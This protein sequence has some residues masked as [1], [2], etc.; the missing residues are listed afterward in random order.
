M[1]LSII[2]PTYN[3]ANTLI[4][5]LEYMMYQKDVEKIDWEIV[6]VDDGSNDDTYKKIEEMKKKFK[7]LQYVFIPRTK[8]SN[9]SRARNYGAKKS[10]GRYISFLDSGMIVPDN[11]VYLTYNELNKNGQNEVLFHY[12]YGVFKKYDDYTKELVENI[13]PQNLPSII[14]KIKNDSEWRDYRE[15]IFNLNENN[16]DLIAPWVLGWGGAISM[17]KENF[18]IVD[19][20]DENFMGWG[21]EDSDLSYRLLKKRIVFKFFEEAYALHLPHKNETSNEKVK[22]SI[23]NRIKIHEKNFELDTELYLIYPSLYYNQVLNKLETLSISSICPRNYSS[24]SM[25]YLIHIIENTQKSCLIGID[26]IYLANKFKTT[27]YFVLNKTTF[28]KFNNHYLMKDKKIHYLLGI[29]TPFKDD[30]YDCIIITDFI[31][32]LG[33]VLQEKI[34]EEN[35]RISKKLYLIYKKNYESIASQI[36]GNRWIYM[37]ELKKILKKNNKCLKIIVENNEEIIFQI[38]SNQNWYNGEN[39]IDTI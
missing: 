4:K 35:Y 6:I 5:G 16:V 39:Y 21:G 17:S 15:H 38:I 3:R 31:R 8:E 36:D 14:N 2:I 20:F 29:Y 12:F 30:E 28:K 26:D 19:G 25:N 18:L 9:R 10:K 27:D 7:N 11:Y 32:Q 23:V 13:N 34:F 24:D 22:S 33:E 1:D 37:D